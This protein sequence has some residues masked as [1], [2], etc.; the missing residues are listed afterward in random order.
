MEV[1]VIFPGNRSEIN[2][3]GAELL[4]LEPGKPGAR[5]ICTTGAL[6]L[7]QQDDPH[8]HVLKAGQSFTLRQPGTVLVQG[9]PHGKALILPQWSG[10]EANR[11]DPIY[12]R[13]AEAE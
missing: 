12:S 4:K 9:V 6:W 10:K 11:I 5:V 13:C 1:Q 8:D 2:L 3:A 7:T